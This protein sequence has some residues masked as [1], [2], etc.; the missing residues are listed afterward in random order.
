MLPLASLCLRI[1]VQTCGK[2]RFRIIAGKI[3][4][5][6]TDKGYDADAI[7]EELANAEAVIPAKNDRREPVPHNRE[8]YRLRNL[9]EYLFNKL[10]NWRRIATRYG[11]TKESSFSRL[12]CPSPTCR[13][14]R[15]RSEGNAAARH[16]SARRHGAAVDA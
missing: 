16:C 11:K 9:A 12:K 4:A 8:K 14:S 13:P 2:L 1:T 5:L 6:L 3:E 7:R 15:H 10:K